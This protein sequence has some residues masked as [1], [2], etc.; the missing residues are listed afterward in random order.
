MQCNLGW[1]DVWWRPTERGGLRQLEFDEWTR[2]GLRERLGQRMV[3]PLN[4]WGNGSMTE[5]DGRVLAP[6]RRARTARS[7]CRSTPEA[8]AISG[9]WQAAA[10]RF[11]A[12]STGQPLPK[13]P[14]DDEPSAAR[15]VAPSLSF[16]IRSP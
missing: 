12:G 6:P 13:S 3:P 15:A 4:F 10:R 2:G 9:A 16:R 14:D 7:I 8:T 1:T 5:M 11:S